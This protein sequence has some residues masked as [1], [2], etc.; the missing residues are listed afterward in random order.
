VRACPACGSNQ[1]TS[2]LEHPDPLFPTG[3]LTLVSCERCGLVFLNP[4]LT[5]SAIARLEDR[6]PVYEMDAETARRE[7]RAREKLLHSIADRAPVTGRLLDVG[8][9]RGLL[10]RA[11]KRLGWDAVGVEIS[12]VAAARAR[13]E[14]Q[15]P[16]Y[17][18]LA[19]VPRLGGFELV[20]AWHVLEHT[21][22]PISLLREVNRLLAPNG[23]LALQVPSFDFAT[24]FRNRGM[25]GSLI[26]AVHAIY[27]TES[28][29]VDILQRADLSVSGLVNSKSDLM[30]TAFANRHVEP[31]SRSSTREQRSS[32]FNERVNDNRV[33]VL[34]ARAKELERQ[35]AAVVSSKSWRMT[36]PLRFIGR[37][38]RSLAGR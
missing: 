28:S 16:V 2:T 30:L 13:S 31:R 25:I 7:I 9:N 20:V 26:C 3:L 18:G 29:L 24:E 27:F 37:H 33:V 15:V 4:R 12:A 8:C 17:E 38:V 22:D 35:L 32:A 23:T 10:L 21:T 34:E 5:R 1:Q 19:D 14:A 6:S 36:A 11:A